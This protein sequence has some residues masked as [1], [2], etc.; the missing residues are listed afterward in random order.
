LLSVDPV[1]ILEDP[2]ILN[3]AGLTINFV[4]PSNF[5]QVIGPSLLLDC[6][7]LGLNQYAIEINDPDGNTS[8]CS[9]MIVLIDPDGRC[10]MRPDEASVAGKIFNLNGAA[11]SDVNVQ[12]Q[13]D[14]NFHT[15][16][17]QF[18]IYQFD[19]LP[20]GASCEIVPEHDQNH[21]LGVS[22]FDMVLIQMHILQVNKFTSP[23]QHIAADVN[24]SGRIDIQDLLEIRS[25]I[26]FQAEEFSASPSYRFMDAKHQFENPDNP[27]SEYIPSTHIC[28]NIEDTQVDLDFISIKIGDIDGSSYQNL[29]KQNITTRSESFFTI[30][31]EDALLPANQISTIEINGNSLAPFS[32]LQFGLNLRDTELINV[33]YPNELRDNINIQKSEIHFAW[34]TFDDDLPKTLFKISLRPNQDISVS[35]ILHFHLQEKAISFDDSGHATRIDLKPISST[36]TPIGNFLGQNNPNPFANNTDIPF[37]LEQEGATTIQIKNLEGKTVHTHTSNY[38]K[39]WHTYQYASNDIAS[40]IYFYSLIQNSTT[41]IKKMLITR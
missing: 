9:N 28:Q 25:L 24:Q 33:D 17:D 10:G 29:D 14:N 11:V 21:S 27:L 1:S 35:D 19:A 22:S 32:A 18:G 39:G 30:G 26:L 20:I 36:S 34:T 15:D 4:D 23:Y 6:D 7:N 31:F 8:V 38:P 13:Y 3:A 16:T 12:L 5:T 40:G 41:Q 37:Y 2:S